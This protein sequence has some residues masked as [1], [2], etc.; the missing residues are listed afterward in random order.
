VNKSENSNEEAELNHLMTM[1]DGCLKRSNSQKRDSLTG[2]FGIKTSKS[3][4]HFATSTGQFHNSKTDELAEIMNR[5]I[6]VQGL[7]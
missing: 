2:G 4:S 5:Q 1:S 7:Q 3:S 6:W